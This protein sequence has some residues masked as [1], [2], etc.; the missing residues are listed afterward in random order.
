[1][2]HLLT[3]TI[4]ALTSLGARAQGTVTDYQRARS[5]Y[6]T[7][8]GKVTGTIAVH[9]RGDS[10]FWFSTTEGDS[11]VYYELNGRTG[12]RRRIENPEPL[13]RNDRRWGGG[14][15]QHHWMEVRDEKDWSAE[16]PVNGA[17]RIVHRDND[18]YLVEEGHADIRL[19]ADG[20]DTC[21]YSS[22]GRWSADG[23]YYATVLI[24]PAPKRYVTYTLSSPSDRVQPRYSQQ[25]YAKPGDSLNIRIPVIVDVQQRRT[26]RPQSTALFACQYHVSAPV[27]S[28][29]Q[30]D[31]RPTVTFEFN[32][33][34]HKTFR[35][36]EMDLEGRVRTIIE[37][38]N[39]KYVAYSRNLRRDLE[40]GRILWKSDRDGHAHLYLYERSNGKCR[41][42]THGDFWVRD[43]LHCECDAKGQG[44]LIFSANGRHCANMG[45]VASNR[46]GSITEEDPYNL[47]YYRIGLNGKGLVDLTPARGNHRIVLSGDRRSLVDTYSQVDQPAVSELRDAVTGTLVC[48]VSRADI[49]RLEAVGWRAPEVFV[50]PGRDG[51]TDIWGII[52]RPSNFDPTKKYPVIEY[53]YSGPGD[54]Y[55]PKQFSTWHGNLA[56]LAELGFIVVQLDGMST[57]F[58]SLAFEQVCYKNLKDA[59]FPDRIAWI[60]AAAAQYPYM[61]ISNMGIYGCSAGGQEALGAL[62][63]HPDFYKVGYAACGCHDNRMD[64]IWWNEQWM[65][66]PVDESYAASSNVEH[67]RNLQGKLMLVV[68]E[69]DDNVD[70]SSTYQVVNAL[71]KAHKDF[72]FVL[73]P[74][75]RH[76][77]GDAYGEHKRYDFFVRHLLGVEP[78]AWDEVQ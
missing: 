51:T 21:Y 35:V 68:G 4:L 42:L 45:R 19:T 3:I 47:H 48:E 34:G 17:Q 40:G 32:E 67:A 20:R 12:E 66:W 2:K 72:E 63:F 11:T 41:Q 27:W 38:K 78:P 26:I 74:G 44:Y 16:S 10:D 6:R 73:L 56:D 58:R 7:Y 55:V 54:Q 22:W 70:P 76:T 14:G 50:A 28:D 49:S 43:V 60:R 33:R 57:S 61:D 75:A 5:L 23:R 77:M 62:L 31:T 9:R 24:K 71:Q 37:E 36:L 15:E 25:E 52:Q 13:R 18:L 1:M 65:G 46:D 8:S 29:W 30:A 69:M 59:G 53:I 39:D 64:K